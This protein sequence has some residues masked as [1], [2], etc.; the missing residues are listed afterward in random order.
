VSL[1]SWNFRGSFLRH[2]SAEVWMTD[3]AGGTAYSNPGPWL[4]DGTWQIVAPWAP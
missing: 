3:G 2:Y 1:E 4:Q